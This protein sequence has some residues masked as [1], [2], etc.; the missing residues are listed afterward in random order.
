MRPADGGINGQLPWRSWSNWCHGCFDEKSGG[1][2][3]G[4][5]YIIWAII[6]LTYRPL[7]TYPP[8]TR[9]SRG[10]LWSRLMKTVGFPAVPGRYFQ[11][12]SLR[13]TGFHLNDLSM[14]GFFFGGVA[15]TRLYICMVVDQ[16][17]C[18]NLHYC[19][20]GTCGHSHVIPQA[21]VP[22]ALWLL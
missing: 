10:P 22:Q 4:Y 14:T 21:S 19:L 13:M 3:D 15:S 20:Y 5:L 7:L 8:P 2:V 9:N 6:N 12:L 18:M 1:M 16:N 11:P 17:Y